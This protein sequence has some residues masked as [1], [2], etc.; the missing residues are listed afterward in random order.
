M[1]AGEC[2]LEEGNCN[3]CHVNWDRKAALDFVRL[4]AFSRRHC[5]REHPDPYVINHLESC[6][7]HLILQWRLTEEEF[8]WTE[9]QDDDRDELWCAS[10]D[11]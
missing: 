10:M 9:E 7:E 11:C 1:I 3:V 5:L 8:L 2:S 4:L 6:I